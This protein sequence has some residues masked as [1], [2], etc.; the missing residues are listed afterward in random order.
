MVGTLAN[1][2]MNYLVTGQAPARMGNAHPNIVPYAAFP[3]SDGWFI[4]AVGNDRQFERFCALTGLAADPRFATNA[5]R[6][7]HRAEVDRAVARVTRQWKRDELLARLEAEGVPA[8]PDQH[9]GTGLCPIRRCAIAGC[10]PARQDCRRLSRE[11][12]CQSA[13]PAPHLPTGAP[14]RCWAAP[15]P[16]RR[17]AR[18]ADR[19]R[20]RHQ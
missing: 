5:G 8:G 16:V 3:T 6:Q 9:R 4:L 11:S 7:E 17:G 19:V 1:Q 20:A 12:A 15:G 18:R 2:A 10:R 13:I 14:R